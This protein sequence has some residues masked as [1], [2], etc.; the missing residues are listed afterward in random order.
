MGMVI[1][2]HGLMSCPL[3]QEKPAPLVKANPV[4]HFGLPFQPKL[5]EKNQVEVC[6]F[7]FDAREQERLALKEKRL[8]GLRNEEVTKCSDAP[9]SHNGKC[10]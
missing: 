5:P 8:E 2:G 3:P 10:S 4:P 7:S 6:P 1:V 9:K